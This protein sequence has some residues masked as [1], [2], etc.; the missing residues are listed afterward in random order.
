M[1]VVPRTVGANTTPTLPLIVA[2]LMVFVVPVSRL[3]LPPNPDG[4]STCDAIAPDPVVGVEMVKVGDVVRID[5]GEQR[6]K[7]NIVGVVSSRIGDHK[8]LRPA[9]TPCASPPEFRRTPLAHRSYISTRPAPA[10]RC[11]RRLG[12]HGRSEHD[13]EER[14]QG[15]DPPTTRSKHGTIRPLLHRTLIVDG[16]F[17]AVIGMR[18]IRQFAVCL[19]YV[20]DARP[21]QDHDPAKEDKLS[22]APGDEASTAYALRRPNSR[23][24]RRLNRAR[25]VSGVATSGVNVPNVV[26]RTWPFASYS[27]IVSRFAYRGSTGVPL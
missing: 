25:G 14:N 13:S 10:A 24:A 7:S 6:R 17:P 1:R 2:V 12:Q 9:S 20:L 16:C 4:T 26:L 8:V 22:R 18:S 3:A 15:H 5:R 27:T 21:V 23:R 19:S 11:Q